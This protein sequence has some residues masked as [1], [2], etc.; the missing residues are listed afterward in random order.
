MGPD[1]GFSMFASNTSLF[2]LKKYCKTKLFQV[3]ADIFF[4]AAILYPRLQW[5]KYL[6]TGYSYLIAPNSDYNL[7]RSTLFHRPLNFKSVF[8]PEL[9]VDKKLELNLLSQ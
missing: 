4:I 1:L 6:N 5:V 7:H 3:D 2:F 9:T 8:D